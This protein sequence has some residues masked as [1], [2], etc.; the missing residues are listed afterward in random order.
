MVSSSAASTSS[1]P[2]PMV[3]SAHC[4]SCSAVPSTLSRTTPWA[5][6]CAIEG[7]PLARSQANIVRTDSGVLTNSSTGQPARWTVS[8]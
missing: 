2:P 5:H 8:R 6:M 3:S 1:G 4:R 7:T